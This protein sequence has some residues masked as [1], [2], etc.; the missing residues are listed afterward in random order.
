MQELKFLMI[1]K[2]AYINIMKANNYF[3]Q[4]GNSMNWYPWRTCAFPMIRH[5]D[6]MKTQ[7]DGP[8]GPI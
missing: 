7:Q 4:Q 2:E 8:D 3:I 1:W 6:Q 5:Y